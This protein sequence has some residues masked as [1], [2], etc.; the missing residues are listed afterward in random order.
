M[1]FGGCVSYLTEKK[2]AEVLVAEGVRSDSAQHM[3]DD[4]NRVR[5]LNPDLNKSVWHVSVS[6]APEDKGKITEELMK[7]ISKDYVDKFGL[8]QYAVIRHTDAKHEHFHLVGN[9]VKYDGKTV[10]DQFC[11]ARGAELS[12]KLE[13]KYELTPAKEKG[14]RLEFTHQDKLKGNDKVKY[15]IYQA[16]NKELPGAKSM[17]ELKEKLKG[18][19]ITTDLKIQSTGR[20]YGVSFSKGQNCFKGSEV[21]KGF[22][23]NNIQ[24]VIENTIKGIL[25]KSIPGL[26]EISQVAGILKKG[27]DMGM[28]M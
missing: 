4:F 22:G 11:A 7:A 13:V 17:E 14:K 27:I 20:V 3:T 18:Y 5:S 8:E 24:K 19:G 10:S 2:G 6:F 16:I 12:N 21:D 15:E 23:I 25:E 26:K 1:S 9:R 28:D